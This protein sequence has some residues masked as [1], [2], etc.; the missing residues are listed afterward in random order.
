MKHFFTLIVAAMTFMVS[1]W[2]QTNT[3]VDIAVDSPDH[4]L[5]KRQSLL[6]TWLAPSAVKDLHRLRPR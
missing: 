5:L 6:L 4:E 3:V 2:S 1:G